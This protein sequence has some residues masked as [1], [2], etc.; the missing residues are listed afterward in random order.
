MKNLFVVTHTQSVHHIENKVGGWYD[1]GLTPQGRLDAASVAEQL[2]KTIGEAPVEIYSSDLLRASQ[3]AAIIAERL[4]SSFE[5]TGDLR[6]IS[7][8]TAGGKPEEWLAARQETA[9]DDNRLDHRGGIADGETRR[10]LAERV[11]RSVHAIISR[12]CT[13]QI[14]VTHGFALTFVVAAWIKMPIDA[15]G[16]VAFPARSGSITHLQQDDYW[17]NR[18]VIRLADTAHLTRTDLPG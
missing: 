6:E 2:S 9:P 10:E 5:A 11:Y 17:R 12:P 7:Y 14:I 18:G 3:T 4:R 16:F 1:T 15:A 13:T 8:G